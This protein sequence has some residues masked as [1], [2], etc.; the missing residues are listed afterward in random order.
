ML[1]L[2]A[3]VLCVAN[4][5]RVVHFPADLVC[6]TFE[7]AFILVRTLNDPELMRGQL[8]HLRHYLKLLFELEP[9][10]LLAERRHRSQSV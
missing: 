9:G 6:T 3:I 7:G 5:V 10:P 1:L 8:A 4:C 2:R